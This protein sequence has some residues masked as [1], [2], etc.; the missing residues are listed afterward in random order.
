MSYSVFL[1]FNFKSKIYEIIKVIYWLFTLST[2]LQT[3]NRLITYSIFK[4]EG[5]FSLSFCVFYQIMGEDIGNTRNDAF[6]PKRSFLFSKVNGK[7]L[8]FRVA[9]I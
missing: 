6:L 8:D 7:Y 1:K 4:L 9:L 3:C 5:A 2:K